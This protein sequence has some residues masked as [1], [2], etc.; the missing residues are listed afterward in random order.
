MVAAQNYC[1]GAFGDVFLAELERQKPKDR[2]KFG[3]RVLESAPLSEQF[4]YDV[5]DSSFVIG[6]NEGVKVTLPIFA[7]L[8]G[9]GFN[10]AQHTD[11]AELLR[12]LGKLER[13]A[14]QEEAK[15]KGETTEPPTPEPEV[16]E[17]E[18]VPGGSRPVSP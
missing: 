6:Y 5:G 1:R 14:R 8:Q 11:D 18:A 12:A 7:K 17:E 9:P 15:A 2:L 4:L 13:D 10:L 16:E 3:V